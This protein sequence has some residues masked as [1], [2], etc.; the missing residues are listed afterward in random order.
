MPDQI[1]LCVV[2]AAADVCNTVNR[3]VLQVLVN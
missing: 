1:L 3:L 2:L